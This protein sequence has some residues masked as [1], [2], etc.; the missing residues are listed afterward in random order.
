MYGGPHVIDKK[1]NFRSTRI[2]LTERTGGNDRTLPPG[3]RLTTE[4]SKTSQVVTGRVWLPLTGRIHSPID[5]EYVFFACPDAGTSTDQTQD[6]Y[7]FSVR[8]L[9]C[10]YVHILWTDWL[11]ESRVRCS[12]RSPFFSE[13]SMFLRAACSQSSPNFNKTQINTN[14]D[15]CEWPLSNPQI[16]Q[17]Y[18]T[19]GYTSF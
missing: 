2:Q 18:F 16:F 10:A 19:L 1:R 8:S 14:W 12:V 5:L 9:Q 4:R 13:S 7:Y 15:W 11:L 3:V 17:K 6:E